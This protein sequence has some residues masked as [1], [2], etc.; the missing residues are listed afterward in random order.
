MKYFL[1][2]GHFILPFHCLE[3]RQL[4]VTDERMCTVSHIGSACPRKMWYTVMITDSP[5]MISAVYQGHKATNQSKLDVNFCENGNPCC[6]MFMSTVNIRKCIS[7]KTRKLKRDLRMKKLLYMYEPHL[8][9][10]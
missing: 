5:Y 2:Y 1:Y 9:K 7:V 3:G 6:K 4:L 8:E 10:T